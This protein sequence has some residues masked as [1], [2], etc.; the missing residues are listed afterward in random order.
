MS[1]RTS[2][3]RAKQPRRRSSTGRFATYE[4]ADEN[5]SGH[6]NDMQIATVRMCTAAVPG[7]CK[8]PATFTLDLSK[9]LSIKPFGNKLDEATDGALTWEV[10]PPIH[11]CVFCKRHAA[12]AM[13]AY[14]S[15]LMLNEDV[16]DFVKRL[17]KG[18]IFTF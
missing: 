15:I 18:N 17:L 13:A 7:G 10:L 6:E 9:G 5:E 4:Y 12:Q 16:R 11:C 8:R 14:A 3:T 2:L 1:S